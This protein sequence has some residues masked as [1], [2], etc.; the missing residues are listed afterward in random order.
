[1]TIQIVA[2]RRIKKQRQRRMNEYNS[3]CIHEKIHPDICEHT[4]KDTVSREREKEVEKVQ[5]CDYNLMC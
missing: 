3:L 5:S 1:M 2:R 4:K